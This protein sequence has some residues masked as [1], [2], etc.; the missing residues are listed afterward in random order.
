MI[1]PICNV[2]DTMHLYTIDGNLYGVECIRCD[3]IWSSCDMVDEYNKGIMDL[4]EKI[5]NSTTF[6]P[7][8]EKWPNNPKSVKVYRNTVKDPGGDGPLDNRD[9]HEYNYEIQVKDHFGD[10]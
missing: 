4:E 6:D 5:L 7:T 3:N 1:C 2:S 8:W 9:A 10:K